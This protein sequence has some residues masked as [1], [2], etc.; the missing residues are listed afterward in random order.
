MTLDEQHPTGVAGGKQ[1]AKLILNEFGSHAR[2]LI[3]ARKGNED[4]R[5]VT[6]LK[7]RLQG[8]GAHVVDTIQGMPID[9]RRSIDTALKNGQGIDVIARTD[10]TATW[11]FF[12][13]I[14]GKF[15]ALENAALAQ[16]TSYRWPNFL[17]ANNLLNVAN[18]IVV[19]AIIA[20]GMTMVIIT[21]SIDLSVGSLI[22]LS[23][24]V[25]TLLIRNF[26]GAETAGP[27]G[28]VLCCLAALA[29][30]LPWASLPVSW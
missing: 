1:V 22:A 23:A 25:S 18:Q 16:P 13:D 8:K 7:E 26:A 24:V 19:I 27:F 21:D 20:I 9:V 10:A 3:A 15:P 6:A 4:E 5:F 29:H 30:A 28:M 12:K 2:V 14:G 11:P 17:K